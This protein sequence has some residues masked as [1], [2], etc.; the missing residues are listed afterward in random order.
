MTNIADKIKSVI[1]V[2]SGANDAFAAKLSKEALKHNPRLHSEQR[3]S[4]EQAFLLNAADE[5]NLVTVNELL[6]SL[7]SI[8][9]KMTKEER[10]DLNALLFNLEDL[11]LQGKGER[12]AAEVF[13]D[14][15]GDRVV[16]YKHNLD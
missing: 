1:L 2:Q 10:K 12:I 16:A 4:A 11:I 15:F 5:D 8:Q 9:Q 6:T 13:V 7:K 14:N 3:D